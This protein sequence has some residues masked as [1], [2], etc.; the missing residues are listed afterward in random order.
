VGPFD[1][2]DHLGR[3]GP[4][5]HGHEVLGRPRGVAALS[6][7]DFGAP[8]A[9]H[10]GDELPNDPTEIPVVDEQAVVDAVEVAGADGPRATGCVEHRRVAHQGVGL[11]QEVAHRREKDVFGAL[12]VDGKLDFVEPELLFKFLLQ[13]LAGVGHRRHGDRRGIVRGALQLLPHCDHQR[14]G[15]ETHLRQDVAHEM[16]HQAV[17]DPEGTLDGAAPARGAPVNG[18]GHFVDM[19]IGELPGLA[20]TGA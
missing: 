3:V 17:V 13:E 18:L 4:T 7:H 9:L 19:L 1:A 16:G 12:D 5:E 15:G 8:K 2:V 10:L 20:K 6:N 11:E 14:R